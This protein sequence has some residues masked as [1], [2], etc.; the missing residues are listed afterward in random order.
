M[1][2]LKENNDNLS[3][4]VIG[5][6]MMEYALTLIDD[7]TDD[8]FILNYVNTIDKLNLKLQQYC[9]NNRKDISLMIESLSKFVTRQLKQ[10]EV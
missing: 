2:K 6:I 10:I 9:D 7:A 8:K 1:I 4:L 5:I 3:E